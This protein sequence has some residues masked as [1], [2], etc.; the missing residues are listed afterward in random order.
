[1]LESFAV[2]SGRIPWFERSVRSALIGPLQVPFSAHSLV[3]GPSSAKAPSGAKAPSSA[4]AP[5]GK[6]SPESRAPSPVE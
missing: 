2:E 1:M 4:K 6:P 3:A 5:E